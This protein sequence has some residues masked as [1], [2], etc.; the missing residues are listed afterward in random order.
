MNL[1]GHLVRLLGWGIGLTEILY[2]Q[3]IQ[4]IKTQTHAS[5]PPA[6]FE[7]TILVFERSKTVRALDRAASQCFLRF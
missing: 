5:M 3:K 7:T 1:F 2:L 6:G 4:Q